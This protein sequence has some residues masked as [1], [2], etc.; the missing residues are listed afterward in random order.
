MKEE[1]L[2][3][4]DEGRAREA[5]LEDLVVD[6]P[7]DPGGRWTAKD[8]LAHLSWWRWRTART[9]EAVR[10]GGE[11]P[12]PTLEGDDDAAQN[13]VIYAE[14]KDRTAADV[15]ADAA[16]SWAALR[17][18]VEA[19]SEED[20]AKPHPSRPESQI[21]ESVPG[22]LGHSGTHVWS[23]L[24]DVGEKERAISVA[25]WASGVE[26]RFFTRPDQLAD[27]RYNLACVHA[28]LGQ[29]DQA[30]PLLRQAFEAKPELRQWALKD[31]DLDGIRHLPEVQRILQ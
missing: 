15:K 12:P 31:H 30:L 16:E 18:A 8:H 23:W 21:W 3:A 25:T 9:H 19:S 10:T 26:A 11:P 28:R 1:L 17:A 29:A 6:A 22:A 5:E 24:L 14:V 7:A 2:R 27:S 20:L 13:A 4:I